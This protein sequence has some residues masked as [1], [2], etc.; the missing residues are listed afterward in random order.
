[1]TLYI[2]EVFRIVSKRALKDLLTYITDAWAFELGFLHT[3]TGQHPAN[4]DLIHPVCCPLCSHHA[5][6]TFPRAAFSLLDGDRRDKPP[7]REDPMIY[8]PNRIRDGP[9]KNNL[10]VTQL[11]THLELKTPHCMAHNIYEVLLRAMY[12][13]NHYMY[14]PDIRHPCDGLTNFRTPLHNVDNSVLMLDH[15]RPLWPDLMTTHGI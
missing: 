7:Q 11:H 9:D 1:M 6:N 12:H 15:M 2:T 10:T 4:S 5:R 3:P 14:L 8:S 13:R